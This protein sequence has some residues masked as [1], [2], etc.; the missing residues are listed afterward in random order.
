MTAYSVS[1]ADLQCAEALLNFCTDVLDAAKRAGADHAEI[2]AEHMGTTDVTI[3]QNALKG[4]SVGEHTTLGLRLYIARPTGNGSV[5]HSMG[6]ASVNR[7]DEETVGTAIEDAIAIARASQPDESMLPASPRPFHAVNDLWD[8]A[9]VEMNS[10]DVVRYAAALLDAARADDGRISVDTG[11]FATSFGHTAI[12][13]STGIYA[14]QSDAAAHASLFGMAIDGEDVSSFDYI[15]ER[16]LRRDQIDVAAFGKRF[17]SRL[18]PLLGAQDGISYKG[19][20]LFAP[21]AF[22]EIFLDVLLSSVDGSRVYKGKSKLKDKHNQHV[23]NPLFSLRDDGTLHGAVGSS[24]FDREG[25]PHSPIDIVENGVL[26]NFL[27]DS[28]SARRM[29]T[30]STGHASGGAS[31]LPSVGT[32]NLRAAVGTSSESSLLAALGRGIYVGRFSG[33]VDAVSGEFSG[34][35]KCSFL[36]E[37]GVKQHAIQ[38]TLVAGNVFDLLPNLVGVGDTLHHNDATAL[39]W[40]L[41]DGVTVTAGVSEEENETDETDET[42]GSDES[43]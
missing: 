16:L 1:P 41:V 4:A 42:D 35:A 27:F 32:T 11:G 12:A 24:L 13:T 6:F 31:S 28:K 2:Y 15:S 5:G 33:N 30:Q 22:E 10:D 8:P 3:E 19:L 26:K 43:A 23:A 38:E 34:V 40:M 20:V 18:L 29:N 25:L 36:V 17:S 14:M 37:N 7:F 21:E 39:P 9:I